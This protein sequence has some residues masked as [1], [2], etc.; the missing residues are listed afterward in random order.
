[1]LANADVSRAEAGTLASAEVK[2]PSKG[3]YMSRENGSKML[4]LRPP[5][6]LGMRD[7]LYNYK[8]L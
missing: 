3:S 6:K 2:T 5:K 7:I 4:V 8:E 1:M